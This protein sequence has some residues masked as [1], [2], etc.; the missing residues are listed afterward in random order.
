M[1]PYK[2]KA[3]AKRATVRTEVYLDDGTEVPVKYSLRLT[4]GGWKVYDVT[5]ENIS[6]IKNFR[7][8]FGAEI[9]R[10]GGG[11][12]IITPTESVPVP[13]NNQIFL[14]ILVMLMLATAFIYSRR[15]A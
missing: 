1:L 11:P 12:I 10:N 9:Q 5:I 14:A 15:S 6:Y 4:D 7:T 3:D 13:V 2:G 8:Q